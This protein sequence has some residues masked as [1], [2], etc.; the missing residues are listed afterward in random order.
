DLA[1]RQFGTVDAVGKMLTL[2]TGDKF[3][4]YLVTGVA[5]RCPQNSSIQF[6]LVLPLI[7][8]K[9][10]ES[11]PYAWQSFFLATY[12][13]LSPHADTR[14]VEEGM[15]EAYRRDAAAVIHQVEEQTK[16][17]DRTFYGLLPLTAMHLSTDVRLEDRPN[18]SNPLY[19]YILSGIAVFILLIGCI[20]F[21]N[22]SVA[23]SMKRAREIGVRKVLGGERLHLIA[24]FMGEA[25]LLCLVA[26]AAA[27]LL[28]QIVL[29]VFNQLANKE[30]SFSYLLDGRLIAAYI[31][32]FLV[33]GL[34]A[35]FYPALV[36]S[37][38]NPVQ[39][40]Y[41]RWKLSGKSYLQRGLVVL[42]FG[43]SSFL[44]IGTVV[45]FTQFHFLT[46]EN[47]G[48]DDSRLVEVNQDLTRPQ[49]KLLKDQLLKDPDISGV[50]ATDAVG[51][52]ED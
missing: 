13:V 26:F 45:I 23:R 17:K 6:D 49:V 28:M 42:Q 32:L 39:V 20:N 12:I 30:L 18:G 44:I 51:K 4:P 48:Y 16:E 52:G 22:L 2:K 15:T 34:L 35:G 31:G 3:E 9:D 46:T 47:L 37:G 8:P 25:M 10:A 19:S 50:A 1:R 43:L 5:K 33:T 41:G 29:P 24:Q 27:V 7:Q 11:Q 40:L 38:F 21:V 36:L 14:A